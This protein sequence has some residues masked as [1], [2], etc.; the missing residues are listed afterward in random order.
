MRSGHI[1]FSEELIQTHHVKLDVRAVDASVPILHV[2]LGRD[3][4]D[5]VEL[6]LRNGASPRS[7]SISGTP[8]IVHAVE[9]GSL[10]CVDLLLGAGVSLDLEKEDELF[11]K[12][13]KERKKDQPDD[14]DT[15]VESPFEGWFI[16]LTGVFS[17]SKSLIQS[18]V[19]ANGGKIQN[20]VN[21]KT[22]H[23]C[24]SGVDGVN[25]YGQNMGKGDK[26]YKESKRRKLPFIDE[27]TITRYLH[28]TNQQVARLAGAQEPTVE[29]KTPII[30][31]VI[32]KCAGGGCCGFVPLLKVLEFLLE[33]GADHH[34]LNEKG[35][36]LLTCAIER[37]N[38]THASDIAAMDY[39]LGII[40]A[41]K[42]DEYDE[43][44]MTPLLAAT[45]ACKWEFV[46]LLLATGNANANAF[47]K[48]PVVPPE[49]P[50]IKEEDQ[51]EESE[52]KTDKYYNKL[53]GWNCFHLLVRHGQ[54]D[55]FVLAVDRTKEKADL[56]ART[57][58]DDE[59]P[60]VLLSC[61]SFDIC[62]FLLC[63]ASV[64]VGA[65]SA[66][67]KNLMHVVFDGT[68]VGTFAKSEGGKERPQ[69]SYNIPAGGVGF[70]GSQSSCHDRFSY[71]HS[72]MGQVAIQSLINFK[73]WRSSAYHSNLSATDSDGM[74]P[75]HY[76]ARAVQG[77][78]CV[79]MLLSDRPDLLE[80]KNSIGN[81]P[82]A[83][84]LLAS[85]DHVATYLLEHEANL[86]GSVF[87]VE[88]RTV[89]DPGDELRKSKQV[90]DVSMY[91]YAMKHDLVGVVFAMLQHKKCD[92]NA[93][94][95]A[96]IG[97]AN[98]D[99]TE[100]LLN[101]LDLR[102][103]DFAAHLIQL[104][105]KCSR[106]PDAKARSQLLSLVKRL[107]PHC[108]DCGP[109]TDGDGNTFLHHFV[110]NRHEVDSLLPLLDALGLK[111]V[112]AALLHQNNC[113]H[114]P[115]HLCVRLRQVR[116][117]RLLLDFDGAEK[118]AL[119]PDN[120]GN[121]PL[122]LLLSFNS[123]GVAVDS[124]VLSMLV[125]CGCDLLACNHAGECA[126]SALGQLPDFQ[127][128]RLASSLPKGTL[129][130]DDIQAKFS[131]IRRKRDLDASASAAKR[132]RARGTY[133]KS[134]VAIKRR[135]ASMEANRK[136][137]GEIEDER[138]RTLAK[139]GRL[140]IPVHQRCSGHQNYEVYISDHGDVYDAVL[141]SSEA[142]AGTFGSNKFHSIQLLVLKKEVRAN[143]A[144]RN[145]GNMTMGDYAR[146]LG[147]SHTL[148][149]EMWGRSDE[150]EYSH[151]QRRR[152]FRSLESGL[153][154]F[155][156]VFGAKTESVLG[157]SYEIRPTA[158]YTWVKKLYE[159]KKAQLSTQQQAEQ[160]SILDSVMPK[161]VS[162]LLR[163]ITNLSNIRRELRSEGV[164]TTSLPLGQT[165]SQSMI[166]EGYRV[167]EEISQTISAV[168]R[169]SILRG[170]RLREQRNEV[171]A[172][173]SK[174]KKLT[175]KL[176]SAIPRGF[177]S[178]GMGNIRHMPIIDTEE[179]IKKETAFLRSLED[180]EETLTLVL[181]ASKEMN[182]TQNDGKDYAESLVCSF[183]EK[184]VCFR[185]ML[186]VSLRP[187]EKHSDKFKL[188]EQYAH[189]S[190]PNSDIIAALRVTRYEEAER[191]AP[192]EADRQRSN[193]R[194]F[195]CNQLLF[196]ST[197]VSNCV[198]ILMR[199]LKIAPVEAPASGFLFGKGVYFADTFE[200]SAGYAQSRCMFEIHNSSSAFE[201][202]N[203]LKVM[204]VCEVAL[205]EPFILRNFDLFHNLEDEEVTLPPQGT[206]SVFAGGSICPDPSGFFVTKKGVGI[207]LGSLG[208]APV[209]QVKIG[210]RHNEY[211]VYDE[212]RVKI[213]Y[214]MLFR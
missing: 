25:D 113:G 35:Q 72:D 185:D 98:L 166:M 87:S 176:Y 43:T 143:T 201:D 175:D 82:L 145:A 179:A 137:A 213:K 147:V 200:K 197:K 121:T 131:A 93:A 191:F 10:A 49:K 148:V 123:Q 26:K 180:V 142:D 100:H 159:E 170:K 190:S 42:I 56:N 40:G 109:K 9:A 32:D 111:M 154:Y 130:G 164:D 17:V 94:L 106:T 168:K 50:Y 205:G 69:D 88:E 118:A 125:A 184:I 59:T 30:F 34:Q 21:G 83:C 51:G 28:N 160:S 104:L 140:A 134:L 45:A 162:L 79:R 85:R 67:G 54:Y 107:S 99:W 48:D 1:D 153:E 116:L 173:Q 5:F 208:P 181:G 11:A 155:N 7:R 204:F 196:H 75:L 135:W 95:A 112:L 76:C 203:S 117:L 167:L 62:K 206:N 202:I 152:G 27:S 80:C 64:D 53:Y 14:T 187:I 24:Y 172:L 61:R 41:E 71:G 29:I 165:V 132:N 199:G 47:V 78:A 128:E 182:V 33:R 126:V 91:E 60:L 66:Q 149:Y 124:D 70:G 174:L 44:G 195:P 63:D 92:L 97:G 129:E 136:R 96:S 150:S 158:N 6:F 68:T 194:G 86:N 186:G 133:A 4:V 55:L 212:A 151:K 18:V 161:E 115:V 31:T 163:V 207:P 210:V 39:V 110:A 209:D 144:R 119:T 178:V 120:L 177:G 12:E 189:A 127:C 102:D 103:G 146:S 22:T 65:Q 138:Q 169:L 108:R 139:F 46:R 90:K 156:E 38:P 23:C 211:I 77:T 37:L 84:A 214:I 105:F 171:Y 183:P 157:V 15:F 13:E 114:N 198:G 3:D 52:K 8:A 193:S 58:T 192:F 74:T 89:I 73:R 81:T 16:V 122:H 101:A 20:A 19:E 36:N 2:A 188:L 57:K 141:Q